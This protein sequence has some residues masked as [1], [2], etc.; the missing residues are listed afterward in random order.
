MATPR[1]FAAFTKA[2]SEW[3]GTEPTRY[4]LSITEHGRYFVVA[5][6]SADKIQVSIALAY[7][8]FA[9]VRT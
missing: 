6:P 8:G 9:A 5:L 7:T 4:L 1:G 2:C 3:E